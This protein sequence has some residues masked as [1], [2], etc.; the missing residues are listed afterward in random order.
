VLTVIGSE[1]VK[2]KQKEFSFSEPVRQTE[3]DAVLPTKTVTVRKA[4][5]YNNNFAKN[6]I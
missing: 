3:E 1:C 4:P 6:E 5:P 2:L